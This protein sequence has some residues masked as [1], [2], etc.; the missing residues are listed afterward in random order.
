MTDLRQAAQQALEALHSEK[1]N[2]AVTALR[3][4]LEQPEQEPFDEAQQAM[5][6][7]L[8]TGTGVLLGGKR[9]DPASMYKQPEQILKEKNT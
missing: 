1:F 4:A 2:K 9:I 5:R 6:D 8:A 7:L 3:K